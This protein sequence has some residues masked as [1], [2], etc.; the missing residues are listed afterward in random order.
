[1]CQAESENTNPV[2][3]PFAQRQDN[4]IWMILY[5]FLFWLFKI[6]TVIYKIPCSD[7]PTT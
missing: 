4:S 2:I 7:Y 3:P 1:M 5:S 6:K